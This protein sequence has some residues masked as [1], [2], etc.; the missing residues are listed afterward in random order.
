MYLICFDIQIKNLVNGTQPTTDIC[1]KANDKNTLLN[2]ILTG[3]I[4]TD[5]IIGIKKIK[6]A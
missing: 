5:Y 4:Y 2:R 3:Q 1:K 6:P